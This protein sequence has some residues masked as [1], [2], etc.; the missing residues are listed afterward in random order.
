MQRLSLRPGLASASRLNQLHHVRA[1]SSTPSIPR[2]TSSPPSRRRSSTTPSGNVDL[3]APPDPTS[4]IRPIIYASTP[5]RAVSSNSPYF[6]GEFSD[7]DFNQLSELELE[8]RLRQERVDMANHRF[9][10]AQNT[11]FQAQLQL[12]L[13]RLPTPSDPP[14]DSDV[15][16]REECLSRFYADWQKAN[17]DKQREWVWKWWSEVLGGL[18]M[19][20]RVYVSGVFRR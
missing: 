7:G 9:W 13:D 17:R 14:T 19:Q 3:I 11:E 20:L 16:L 15:R 5:T 12:R 1:S 18:K 2:P 10:A 8:W 4:N 6:I